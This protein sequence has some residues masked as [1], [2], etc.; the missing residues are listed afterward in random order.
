MTSFNVR[1]KGIFFKEYIFKFIF[2]IHIHIYLLVNNF[3]TIEMVNEQLFRFGN[4]L[5]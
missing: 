1:N 2:K 5:H 4:Y 3:S